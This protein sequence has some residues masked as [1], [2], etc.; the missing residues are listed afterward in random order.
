MKN[1]LSCCVLL[2]LF[3]AMPALA[4]SSTSD[5]YD[6]AETRELKDGLTI[7]VTGEVVNP[8]QV[9]ITKFPLRSVIV[10]ETV[11]S[12]KGSKFVGA[13]RYDGYSLYDIL[14]H[15]VLDKKNKGEFDRVIDLYV[16]VENDKG[17]VAVLSWG[18]I[19]YPIHRHEILVATKVTPIVPT[20]SKEQWPLPKETRLVVA[21]DLLTERN[22]PSPNKI[23]IHSVKLS[24]P[25]N[26]KLPLFSPEVTLFKEGRRIKALST[27]PKHLPQERYPIVFYGR[28]RGIHDV[29]VFQG[30]QLREVFQP[31]Y[32]VSKK[33]LQRGLFVVAA[34]D[35]YRCA[36]TFSEIMNRNDQSEVLVIDGGK[37]KGGLFRL[38]PSAD[39]FSDR[40]VKAVKEIHLCRY[41]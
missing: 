10:K 17:D 29:T 37:E 1:R 23:T 13:Y 6:D 9:E 16:T 3:V 12:G 24:F 33:A 27:Y 4:D 28:G 35:G 39:F 30:A 25:V 22:I 11:L 26:R 5:F 31:Y 18:E 41:E 32:P 7:T 8:G 20:K 21:S 34:A 19:Y 2:F 40:A 38:L 15:F 36:Y 14:N